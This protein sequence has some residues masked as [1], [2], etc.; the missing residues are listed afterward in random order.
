MVNGLAFPL[1][2]AAAFFRDISCP[3]YENRLLLGRTRPRP[4]LQDP[5]AT[6]AAIHA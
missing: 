5:T 3:V 4:C 2:A 6:A 1:L